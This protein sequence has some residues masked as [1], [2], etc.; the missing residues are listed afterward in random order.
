MT[1]PNPPGWYDDPNDRKAQRYWDGQDW[2]PHRQRKPASPPVT[3][4][5]PPPPTP[6]P[7]PP[8]PPGS[9]PDPTVQVYGDGQ[10][11]P[12]HNPAAAPPVAAPQYGPADQGRPAPRSTTVQVVRALIIGLVV[13]VVVW[14]VGFSS[15]SPKLRHLLHLGGSQGSTAAPV[16]ET[17]LR[18]LLLSVDQTNTA[19]G[20]TGISPDTRTTMFDESSRVSDIACAP[21]FNAA[22]SAVYAGSGWTAVYG[23]SAG[24]NVSSD[25]YVEIDQ[26]V[27]LF[28]SAQ[29]ANAFY[30]TSAQRWPACSNRQFTTTTPP[31]TFNVG[32]VSN[33]DGTLSATEKIPTQGTPD[34]CERAL[35]VANNVAIDVAACEAASPGAAVNIAH[36]I[37]AKV[38][39]T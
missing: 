15:L 1:T 6:L 22:E 39:T 29:E 25:R 5:A 13:A 16:T 11:W 26:F 2:T 37:A 20:A 21:L 8:P 17:A 32:P 30:S 9:Y 36:Q 33:T 24:G 31:R 34:T 35:T 12:S 28:P 4:A 18:G 27:V 23:N 38:P 3:P 14:V 19:M 10:Q 7:P